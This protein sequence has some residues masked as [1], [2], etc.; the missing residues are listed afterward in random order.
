MGISGSFGAFFFKKGSKKIKSI[1]TFLFNSYVYIGAFFYVLASILNIVL[2]RKLPYIT[3]ISFGTLIYVWS[4]ILALILLKEK[5]SI[6]KIVG[7][8][9]IIIGVIFSALNY[10]K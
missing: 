5:I 1:K 10:L 8:S 2:L 9:L 4:F 6:Y 3:V 7:I